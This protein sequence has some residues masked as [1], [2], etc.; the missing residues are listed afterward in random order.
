MYIDYVRTRLHSP[1][2]TWF[3]AILLMAIPLVNLIFLLVWAFGDGINPNKVTWARAALLW[4]GIW[5][6]LS[7]CFFSTVMSALTTVIAK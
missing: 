4:M 2:A 3:F 7:L 1:D 5:F 6:V